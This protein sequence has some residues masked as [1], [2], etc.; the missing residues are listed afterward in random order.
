MRTLLAAVLLSILL[1]A[2]TMLYSR[3]YEVVS[4]QEISSAEKQAVFLAFRDFLI[5]KGLSPMSY[6]KESNPNRAAF[7]IGGS[8]AGFALRR[9]FED[10]LELTYSDKDGFR[11]QLIRI[12]HQRAD[13]SDEYL[14]N[15]VKQT[16]DFIREA[17]SRPVNLKLLPTA[18][19]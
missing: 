1:S 10:I 16:E 5:S 7:R 13:F 6:G 8:N 14:R 4:T 2:C 17:T 3:K 18:A 15:F 12:V 19:P 11:L 9:D